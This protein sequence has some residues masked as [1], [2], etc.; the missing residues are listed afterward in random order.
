MTLIRHNSCTFLVL[1][2]FWLTARA[3]AETSLPPQQLF[4]VA[5]GS[6]HGLGAQWDHRIGPPL[7]ALANRP[8]AAVANYPYSEALLSANIR[9]TEAE[10]VAWI[11]DT[12]GRLNNTRM[13]YRNSLTPEETQRL[14]RWLLE[15]P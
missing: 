14:S 9:W 13:V 4:A 10:L 15:Q 8:A 2:V 5:C 3:M 12:N 7:G 6:C 11:L 1:A